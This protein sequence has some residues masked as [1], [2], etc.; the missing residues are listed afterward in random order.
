MAVKKIVKTTYIGTEEAEGFEFTFE[1]IEDSLTISKTAGGY[2]ARYL[3]QDNADAGSLEDNGDDGLFLVGYHRDFTVDRGKRV[4]G[5][6]VPGISRDLAR[7]IA[8]GVKLC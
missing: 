7:R 5:R 3:V 2:E 6:H 8:A 1:P 4:D